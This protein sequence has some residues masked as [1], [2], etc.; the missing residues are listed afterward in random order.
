VSGDE[1]L[2][3]LAYECHLKNDLDCAKNCYEEFLRTNTSFPEVYNNLATIYQ[4]QNDFS[5]AR[6]YYEKALT[7]KPDYTDAL[8][9]IALLC[10]HQND[11]EG[12]KKYY[13]LLL[14]YDAHNL[15]ALNNLT[16]FYKY[17]NRVQ[18]AFELAQ[19]ALDRDPE[20]V[21]ALNNI[22]VLYKEQKH[23]D[24]AE[25]CYTKALLHDPQ[26]LE[27]VLNLSLLY[28]LQ[29]DYIKGFDLY[30]SRYKKF[31]LYTNA[32]LVKNKQLLTSFDE[33]RGKKVLICFEQGFGDAIQFIRLSSR[34]EKL[35]AE[36]AY[37][38]PQ[39]LSKLFGYSFPKLHF[40]QTEE[41]SNY[42]YYLP[43]MDVSFLSSLRYEDIPFANGYLKVNEADVKD[44][45]QKNFQDHAKPRV[46]FA[47][48]GSVLHHND[49]N[50]SIPLEEF[51]QGILKLADNMA[52]YSLQYGSSDADRALLEKYGI[53]DLGEQVTDFYDTAVIAECMDIIISIDSSLVH[54]SGALGKKTLL[55]LPFAP[56]W[57]WGV[58]DTNTN[59][60]N[61][62]QIY[63][64]AV[65]SHWREPF[66]EI[67]KDITNGF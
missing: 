49:K 29:K 43:I 19:K 11:F 50:R 42:E 64:Q 2:L 63:R 15:S 52:L 23:L 31:D 27:S 37:Y 48:A 6:E 1:K 67:T 39:E 16:I 59:W 65:P 5:K 35:D 51:I 45:E 57:R 60:Y 17:E 62:V 33:V 32:E 9:N 18:E 30:R 12:A 21:D 47:Y 28:L 34:L 41:L 25:E 53:N 56:D 61:S 24:K 20:N 3:T 8:K 4:I 54:V 13:E 58:D 44:F 40:V 7:C 36:F 55:L 14:K 26:C 22:G 66:L 38:I 10:K 46:G